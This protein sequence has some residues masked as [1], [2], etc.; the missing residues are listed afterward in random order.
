[1]SA[2]RFGEDQQ[3]IRTRPTS[4]PLNNSQHLSGTDA[5]VGGHL[6]FVS[7]VDRVFEAPR[8]APATFLTAPAANENR[9]TILSQAARTLLAAAREA[10]PPS[11]VRS[12]ILSAVEQEIL[13]ERRCMATTEARS[14]ESGIF[15]LPD[16]APPSTAQDY[17]LSHTGAVVLAPPPASIGAARAREQS[18]EFDSLRACAAAS[19]ALDGEQTA[20]DAESCATPLS[21]ARELARAAGRGDSQATNLLLRQISPRVTS[22][23]RVVIGAAHPDIDDVVQHAL[24]AFVQALPAFRGECEPVSYA[25]RIAMRIAIASRRRARALAARDGALDDIDPVSPA[26][27]PHEVTASTR[28][29]ECLRE[30]LH[31]IPEEQAEALGLR[32]VLGWS[33]EEVATSMRVPVNT[34]RSRVRLAKEA[35]RRRIAADP[36]LA[37]ELG[38]F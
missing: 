32:I 17:S 37:D 16:A 33:L 14:Q 7:L 9:C 25:C 6:F 18:C 11:E 28:R 2:L 29:M 13:H 1:M 19:P 22:V 8:L 31:A 3:E 27:S 21:P 26:Q 4:P 34:V 38:V 30:L 15:R 35:L 23:V 5:N 10:P 20:A 24:V 36:K 12:R